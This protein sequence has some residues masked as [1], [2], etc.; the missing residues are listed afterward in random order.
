MNRRDFAGAALELVRKLPLGTGLNADRERI[1]VR[2]EFEALIRK[3]LGDGALDFRTGDVLQKMFVS[4]HADTDRLCSEMEKQVRDI[5]S[6]MGDRS[7]RVPSF[8]A[9]MTAEGLR[10]R[11]E[12]TREMI[13]IVLDRLAAD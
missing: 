2:E 6:A 3:G 4:L 7:F 13:K 8:V 5:E 12:T 1:L 9:A 10:V 11:C